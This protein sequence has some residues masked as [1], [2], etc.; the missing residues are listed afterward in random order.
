MDLNLTGGNGI[1][2]EM[3][4]IAA[5]TLSCAIENV[6]GFAD[7]PAK[8]VGTID[9]SGGEN[10]V[11]DPIATLGVGGLTLGYNVGDDGFYNLSGGTL[12]SEELAAEPILAYYPPPFP[13]IETVG[14]SGVG[15]FNQTGGTNLLMPA[16]SGDA[17]ILCLGSNAGSTGTYILSGSASLTVTGTEFVGFGGVGVFNQTGGTNTLIQPGS[18]NDDR[19]AGVLSICVNYGGTGTYNLSGG[20]LTAAGV[21]IDAEVG[22]GYGDEFDG[23]GVLDVSGGS[24]NTGTLEVGRPQLLGSSQAIMTLTGGVVTASDLT[25]NGQLNDQ[26][27]SLT[28]ASATIDLGSMTVDG[29]ANCA[30]ITLGYIGTLTVNGVLTS[31]NTVV[32]GILPGFSP[33]GGTLDGAGNGSTTGFVANVLLISGVI[34]PGNSVSAIGTLT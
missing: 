18:V 12:L 30:T 19:D 20:S 28:A 21:V 10:L 25:V 24:L 31:G 34:Q 1:N 9:Q 6:G 29:A 7:S 17:A 3:L 8:G 4:S 23:V 5:N 33:Q 11:N 2:G 32:V 14:L 13:A 27:G 15:V 22:L 16:R 26:A